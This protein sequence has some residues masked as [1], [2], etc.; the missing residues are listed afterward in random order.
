[1]NLL[2][3]KQ[4]DSWAKQPVLGHQEGCKPSSR[5]VPMR[6]ARRRTLHTY[7]LVVSVGGLELI[8]LCAF[9]AAD[10][11]FKGHD[12]CA[13]VALLSP[14]RSERGLAGV[15]GVGIGGPAGGA[16]PLECS[17]AAHASLIMPESWVP[18]A[19][20]RCPFGSGSG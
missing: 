18:E 1:M 20:R 2:S 15:C 9:P 5:G 3:T 10:E 17:R 14:E 11:P 12:G 8:E 7:V 16:R 4:D 13:A 6:P 19:D